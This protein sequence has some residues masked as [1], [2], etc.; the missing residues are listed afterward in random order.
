MDTKGTRMQGPNTQQQEPGL[1][2]EHFTHLFLLIR[3]I[4]T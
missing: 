3:M 2:A 4:T 1:G